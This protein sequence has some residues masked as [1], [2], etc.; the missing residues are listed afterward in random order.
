LLDKAVRPLADPDGT[1]AAALG[2]GSGSWLLIRPDGYLAA[3][4]S[5]L[6]WSVLRTALSRA[7]V[8]VLAGPSST[9]VAVPAVA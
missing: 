6:D 2:G 9:V 1:L 4:G 3:R 8:R 7:H 5:A